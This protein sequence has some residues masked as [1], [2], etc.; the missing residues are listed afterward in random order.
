M[1]EDQKYGILFQPA[2]KLH[3]QWFKEMVRL[4]GIYVLYRA[5]LPDKHYTTY[6]EIESNFY[7]PILVGCLFDQHPSQRTTKKLGW[8][9]E[10]Q[11]GSSLIHVDYDLPHL[12]IGALFIVP[13]GLDDGKGRLF[14]VIRMTNSMMYPS[15]IVCEIIPEYE[16]TL[17]QSTIN[18]FTDNSFNLLQEETIPVFNEGD[19]FVR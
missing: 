17:T 10:L 1:K 3:R 19:Y 13:S 15:S 5:P 4:Q 2:I 8:V 12:Q 9:A 16:D 18:D 7:P 11:E 14:R 6:A